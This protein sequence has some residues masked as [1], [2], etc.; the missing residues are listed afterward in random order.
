M[1]SEFYEAVHF[2]RVAGHLLTLSD[3]YKE[4]ALF[5]GYLLRLGKVVKIAGYLS[6][7][8]LF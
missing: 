8:Q 6:K 1:L 2:V 7:L 5:V 4:A 3:P